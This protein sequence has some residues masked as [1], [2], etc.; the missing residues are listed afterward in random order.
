MAQQSFAAQ[1]DAWV[2]KTKE[3]TEAVFKESAQ[4]VLAEAQ[5]PVGAGGN[6]PVDTGF[7]RASLQATINAPVAAVTFRTE[8]QQYDAASVALVIAGAQLGD[9]IYGVYTANYARYVEYGS[10]GRAGRGF[11]RLAAQQWP[12]IVSQVVAEAKSRVQTSE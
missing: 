11:V 12:Q 5:K 6:M 7:L 3:R 9:T 4:R 1:V 2:A 8:G 10:R